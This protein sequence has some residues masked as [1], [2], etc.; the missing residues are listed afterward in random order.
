MRGLWARAERWSLLHLA[1]PR[2]AQAFVPQIDGLRFVAIF[3]VVLYHLQGYV[4]AKI[5][6][7]YTSAGGWLHR[8]FAQG[9]YGVPLFFAIS[10]YII[11]RQFAGNRVVDLRPYFV[12]RLTRLEPP[13]MLSMLVIFS[14]KLY[15][16]DRSFPDLWPHLLASMLYAHGLVFASHSEINGVAWS[17][18]VEWQFYLVAPVLLALVMRRQDRWRDLSLWLLILVGGFVH[19]HA[20]L[21]GPRLD[22]SL[23]HY[24]GFF[25]AGVWVATRE[26]GRSERSDAAWY[27]ALGCAAGLGVLTSLLAGGGYL[28]LLP[29]FTALLL[30]ASLRGAHLRRLLGWWPLH[31]IGAMCYT[32]YLYHF[33]V[34]SAAGRVVPWTFPGSDSPTVILALFSIVAV[35]LVLT[36]CMAPYLLIER[37]FMVWRPGKTRLRDAFRWG[38]T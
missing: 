2:P 27:D 8:L 34:I 14:A 36:M 6:L 33:F 4:E 31:C 21:L 25:L 10:G 13:Y 35:P 24:F 7:D 19:A 29:A 16:L 5:S 12:R 38:A 32:I 18:E 11:A 22:L 3:A 23:L 20:K 9:H 1:R 15:W 37:P 26:D 28:S 17:L 30:L